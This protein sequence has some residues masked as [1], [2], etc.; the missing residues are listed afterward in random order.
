MPKALDPE[1]KALRRLDRALKAVP[2]T[3]RQRVLEWAVARECRMPG[4]TL[5]RVHP[6]ERSR[7]SDKAL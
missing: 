4:I 3:A 5:P 1:I 6:R 7:E 2:E